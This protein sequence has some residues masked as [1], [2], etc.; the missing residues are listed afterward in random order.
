MTLRKLAFFL[1]LTCFATTSASAQTWLDNA[2]NVLKGALESETG[3][4]VTGGLSEAEIIDGLKE[5]LRVGTDTVTGQLGG[6]DGFNADPSIHIPLPEELATAQTYLKKVGLGSLGD[7]VELR[8]NRA[9]E[10]SMEEAKTVVVKAIQD[11]TLEDAKSILDGPDDAATQY[12]RKV[13]EGDLRGRIEPIVDDA[14]T[15]VGAVQ[16][17][18]EML[19]GYAKIPFVPDVKGDLGQHAT[20]L[21]L[22]GL[23]KYLA[24]EEAAIRANPEKQ[25]TALLKKVFAN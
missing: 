19:S 10:A 17:L 2:T 23:F 1:A 21:T 22:D 8:M 5:A 18:D 9:A 13:G 20:D 11:M 4:S 3:Q 16:A 6:L 24:K 25:V 15:Q 14:L 7:E 12:F